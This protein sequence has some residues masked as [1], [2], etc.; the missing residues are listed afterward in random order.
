M[1]K[2]LV[3][4]IIVALVLVAGITYFKLSKSTAPDQIVCTKEAKICP[5]GSTVGRSGPKCE[6]E[7]CPAAQVVDET[8]NWK[9]YENHAYL[10]YF[11]YPTE[12]SA[13]DLTGG[14]IVEI[15]PDYKSTTK[16]TFGYESGV[17]EV[18]NLPAGVC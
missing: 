9:V 15:V 16:I 13:K 11:K 6:F 18:S 1:K 10:I 8:E 17:S 12:F 3:A 2:Y 5:D 4:L 7:E 14:N